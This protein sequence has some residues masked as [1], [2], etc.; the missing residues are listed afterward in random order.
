[1]FPNVFPTLTCGNVRES[2][3]VLPHPFARL[4]PQSASGTGLAFIVFSEAVVEMP[5]A[6]IWAILFF[7]MLFS[8]G[9]SSMFGNLE[10]VLTPIRDLQLLPVWIPNALVTGGLEAMCVGG[11][12][13]YTSSCCL[14]CEK[15][16]FFFLLLAAPAVT[17]LMA[18]S[19]ALIFT[20]ASGNYWVEIFNS[21]VGSVPLLIVAFFEI[22]AVI[23]VY[24][25]KK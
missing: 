3:S 2:V 15:N 21:Y 10:G 18:F 19:M 6:Q 20:M 22:I 1:M 16:N 25:M 17:C 7:T 12:E 5:G 23:Y 14:L 8:L 11:L 24:G 4:L 9:L 13:R